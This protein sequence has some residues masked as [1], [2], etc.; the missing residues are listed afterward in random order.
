[1][2]PVCAAPIS[3]ELLV[4]YWADELDA[5]AVDQI[6]EHVMGCAECAAA[7]AR[8]AALREAVR[9]IIPTMLSRGQVEALRARGL[10]IVENPVRPETRELAVFGAQTDL[11]IHR[12]GGLDFSRVETAHVTVSVESTGEVLTV[13]PDAPFER[14][15]GEI[16]ICCQRHFAIYPSNVAFDVRLVVAGGAER[17]ARYVVPHLFE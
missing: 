8:M 2:N 10:R 16:L 7:S 9:Q 17:K 3:S 4:E 1:M 14:E 12:L 13:E 5:V 6:D 11:L 15:T